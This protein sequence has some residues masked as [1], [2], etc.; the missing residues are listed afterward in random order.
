MQGVSAAF[1]QASRATVAT[2]TQAE[3]HYVEASRDPEHHC[4]ICQHYIGA[5]MCAKVVAEP[6]PIMETGVC[7][8]FNGIDPEPEVADEMTQT[9]LQAKEQMVDG[10]KGFISLRVSWVWEVDRLQSALYTIFGYNDAW[11]WN[12][13]YTFHITLAYSDAITNAQ[14]LEAAKSIISLPAPGIKITGIGV[15][16]NSEDTQA[17]YLS[18]E[19]NDKLKAI[20]SALYQS[21]TDQGVALSPYNLPETWQPH[22]TLAYVPAG[23]SVPTGIELELDVYRV[24]EVSF[25]RSEYETLFE[26]PLRW[27]DGQNDLEN[28]NAPLLAVAVL[29][30]Q[31][32]PAEWEVSLSANFPIVKSEASAWNANAAAKNVLDAANFAQ[33]DNTFNAELARSAFL[34]SNP[35]A[36]ASFTSYLI[37]VGNYSSGSLNVTSESLQAASEKLAALTEL[38]EKT[39]AQAVER[40]NFYQSQLKVGEMGEVLRTTFISEMKGSYPD[41]KLPDDIDMEALGE[42]AFFV[43]LPIG[44]FNTMSRNGR[45]YTQTAI[46]ELVQQVNEMRPEG[47]WGHMTDEEMDTR[48]DPPAIRWLAA[49]IDAEGVAWAKG[50]PLNEQTR[51]YYRM[52]RATNAR[53][54]TSLVAMAEMQKSDVLHLSLMTIDIADPV[55]VGV[56]MT[57]A[58]PKITT[59]MSAQQGDF[60]VKPKRSAELVL[61]TNGTS[62]GKGEG[63]KAGVTTPPAEAKPNSVREQVQVK[64]QAEQ[65]KTSGEKKM[66]EEQVKELQGS[67]ATLQEQHK[68]TLDENTRLTTELASVTESANT[69]KVAIGELLQDSIIAT[70]EREIKQP[71]LRKTVVKQVIA[72]QPQSREQV[73]AAVKAWMDDEDN[74][75]LM[76]FAL[77]KEMGERQPEQ[78]Q[79]REQ[80]SQAKY[81]PAKGLN[82]TIF[83]IPALEAVP[84][85]EPSQEN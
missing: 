40:L 5:G 53:V 22:I 46:E 6:D 43:T 68:A 38:D 29:T 63:A 4:S 36:P 30:Q 49:E 79:A 70:V 72:Q 83:K 57:A 67:F 61:S 81:D 8:L 59:E 3:T 48:Y 58:K 82:G 78:Q 16:D 85:S 44:Q 62:T 17:L 25:S 2:S 31:V 64:K 69:L 39:R 23:T 27:Q 66:D 34:L 51:D 18:V 28:G 24:N 45:R 54:G 42:Q 11:Q 26:I 19:P 33:Q 9:K 14:M 76:K 73:V 13:P 15:F 20:Q 80:S 77:G 56:A 37:P 65:P 32:R 41:V 50:I 74:M 12:D 84:V 75:E 60:I 21:L 7:D 1:D 71:A 52:A 47:I 35:C 55:R 10:G